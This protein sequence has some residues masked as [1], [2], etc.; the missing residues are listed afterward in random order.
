MDH[1][2]IIGQNE[3]ILITGSS[4][5]IGIRLVERLVELGFHNLRCFVR[6]SSSI[7]EL[8][9]IASRENGR[10]QIEILKGNLTHREDCFRAV[11]DIRVIF[12]LAAG[13]GGKSIPE[14]YM[15]SVVSTRNLLDA[16]LKYN[17]LRRFVNIS[18]FAVYSNQKKPTWRL[19][20]E[21]CPVEPK[22][23]SLQDAYC[24][25]KVKQDALVMEYGNKY[26]VP[27][28]IVRPGSVYGPG[29]RQITS[30]VGIDTFGFFLHL[31]G[32]NR[33]PFTYVDNCADAIAL[34]GLIPGVDGE[35]FN[36]VDDDLPTS[37]QFL[38][39]YKQNVN[40][41][42]SIY[43]PHA[44]SYLFYRFWEKYSVWSQ[45]QLPPSFNRR[46]W[47]VEIKKTIYSNDKLKTRLGWTPRVSLDEG[48]KRFF[49]YCLEGG[50]NV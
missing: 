44:V 30:R 27:Y 36:V 31:G 8:K 32:G 16:T 25:A 7:D 50:Q 47:H 37:R 2:T 14:A 41:F 45:G 34:A 33:I 22:P 38:R 43:V 19:L 35:V 4:G 23:E 18:S 48:L 29:K 28:V 26:A 49:Q 11:R 17:C 21:S 24:Y 5:F 42:K 20:N 39:L 13:T 6:A 10:A 9:A 1:E 40:K 46:R 15:N 12:H 3:P